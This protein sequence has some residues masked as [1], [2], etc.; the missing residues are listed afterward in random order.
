MY[1]PINKKRGSAVE[2]SF[3]SGEWLDDNFAEYGPV[4]FDII[5]KLLVTIHLLALG[6]RDNHIA[7]CLLNIQFVY[8]WRH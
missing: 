3:V 1:V 8:F 5:L 6:I 7:I 4:G 2:V